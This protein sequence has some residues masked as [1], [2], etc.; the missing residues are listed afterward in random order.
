VTDP[1]EGTPHTRV[2]ED[3]AARRRQWRARTV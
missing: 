3:V 1:H 2:H